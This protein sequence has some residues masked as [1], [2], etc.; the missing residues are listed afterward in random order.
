PLSH[1]WSLAVEEH[2]YLV[3]PAVVFGLRREFSLR[4]CG[5]VIAVSLLV[6]IWLVWQ[7]ATLAAYCLTICR[8]DA[9]AIG[10]FIALPVRGEEGLESLLPLARR[11]ILICG[12]LLLALI[13]WRVGLAFHDSP[14]QAIG[15][16]LLD[17]FFASLLVLAVSS[18]RSAPLGLLLGHSSLRF[19]GK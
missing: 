10:A 5:L 6:R 2:F 4:I 14:I 13:G 9:L 16:P 11:G 7:G 8:M 12:A 15:Y 19:L 1:F 18:S 17:L 3:W